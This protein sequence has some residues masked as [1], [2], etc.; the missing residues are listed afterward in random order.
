MLHFMDAHRFLLVSINGFFELI[1]LTESHRF[2][3]VSIDIF[4]ELINVISINGLLELIHFM[5]SLTKKQENERT[6][7]QTNE[8]PNKHANKQTP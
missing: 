4:I 2:T 7:E 3:L 1:V 5:D 8:H 6:D